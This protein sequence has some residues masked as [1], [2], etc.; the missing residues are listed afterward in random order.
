MD[1]KSIFITGCSSGIGL[2]AAHDLMSRGYYVIAG[3]RKQDDL[4]KLA[5]EGFDTVQIDLDSSDSIQTAAQKV[6]LLCNDR[7]YAL[8][9]NAGFGVYGALDSISRSEMERQ[10]A[11]NFFGVHELTQALL[12]AMLPHKQGRI[13][14]S[15][16]IMGFV[17][18]PGRGAYAAS[19]Y[20]LEGWTDALRLE[21]LPTGIQVSLL[22]PGPVQT[23]FSQN[24]NQTQKDSPVQNPG[25]AK[26][27]TVTAEAILPVLHHALE[28]PRAKIRYPISLMT[29]VTRLLKRVLP[30]RLMDKML[31]NKR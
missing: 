8:F 9:N 25:I 15:S 13:I 7:L 24:V 27:F 23:R 12:P 18:T 3:C 29:K 17:A 19:K 22:E 6:R 11:T 2:V 28:S 4:E 5:A 30:D 1:K 16:S 21:L 14:Q 26:K 20:A 31:A 10:F